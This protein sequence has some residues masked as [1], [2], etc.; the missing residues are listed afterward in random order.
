MEKLREWFGSPVASVKTV[1]WVTWV[2]LLVSLA[3]AAVLVVME[4]FV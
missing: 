2:C 1:A 4:A 3:L